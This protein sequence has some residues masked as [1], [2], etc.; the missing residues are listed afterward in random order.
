MPW[1][2]T[3]I[4]NE[5]GAG[6][7]GEV[8]KFVRSTFAPDSTALDMTS[9]SFS[10]IC[11]MDKGVAVKDGGGGFRLSFASRDVVEISRVAR[12]VLVDNSA[13]TERSTFNEDSSSEGQIERTVA[14]SVPMCVVTTSSDESAMHG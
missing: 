14:E 6:S 8:I 1:S 13:I 2:L 3:T 10:G 9:D 4:L 7:E 12:S 11:M 5:L